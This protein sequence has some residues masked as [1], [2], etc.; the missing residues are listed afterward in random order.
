ME[1]FL[2]SWFE[3]PTEALLNC[4]RSV[5]DL[6]SPSLAESNLTNVRKTEISPVNQK[7]KEDFLI[8]KKMKLRDPFETLLMAILDK[9]LSGTTSNRGKRMKRYLGLRLS[10]LMDLFKKKIKLS[11]QKRRPNLLFFILPDH[12]FA[13]NYHDQTERFVFICWT[14]N[15]TSPLDNKH[16]IKCKGSIIKFE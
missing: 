8:C 5:G 12:R 2:I 6:P 3:K 16:W 14:S 13:D 1:D 9:F 15:F 10:N 4:I 11:S 7:F